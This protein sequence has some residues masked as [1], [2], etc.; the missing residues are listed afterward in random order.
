MSTTR[1]TTPSGATP[2]RGGGTR[3]REARITPFYR[4]PAVPTALLLLACMAFIAAA[5]AGY[6]QVRRVL[7]VGTGLPTGQIVV[8]ANVQG[9]NIFRIRSDSVIDRVAT[10]S[11]VVVTR[12]ETRFPDTVVIRARV[13]ERFAAWRRG[14]TLY[15]VDPDGRIVQRATS[16]TLPIVVSPADGT[17]LG[18]GVV[19]AVRYA[20]TALP[21]AP[22]GAVAGYRFDRKR[23]LTV[24][25]TSG[26]QAILGTGTPRALD[27]RIATLVAVL[28]QDPARAATLTFIDLRSSEP[29]ARFRP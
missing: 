19:Q 9:R 23:G 18:P 14:S 6:F 17:A 20:Q 21:A 25:G 7:V 27:M 26:W 8:A 10:V 2:R 24:L 12:V 1:R 5:A 3:A 22:S 11:Q 4:H 28:R 29:Y 16:T 13:R 15:I